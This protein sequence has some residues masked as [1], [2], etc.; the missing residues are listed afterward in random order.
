MARQPEVALGLPG[1]LKEFEQL[2]AHLCGQLCEY[3]R[4]RQKTMDLYP[5][6]VLLKID[7]IF[8]DNKQ[9]QDAAVEYQCSAGRVNWTTDKSSSFLN[10]IHT[11]FKTFYF[12]VSNYFL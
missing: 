3:I 4:A 1:P 7:E 11:I 8:F 5:S 10:Q 12:E 2:L 6:V 9:T